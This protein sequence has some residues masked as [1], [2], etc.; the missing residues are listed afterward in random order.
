MLQAF[1]SLNSSGAGRS[2]GSPRGAPLST[3]APIVSISSSLSDESSLKC[4][5][6]MFFS[7]NQGGISRSSVRSLIA[8]AQGR[9]SS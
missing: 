7:M 6:P 5:I 4:W 3:Q 2:A 9:T 8:L 1:V